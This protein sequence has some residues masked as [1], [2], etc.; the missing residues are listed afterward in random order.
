MLTTGP[1]DGLE[2]GGPCE[3]LEMGG[4][5]DGLDP[6]AADASGA[7]GVSAAGLSAAGGL[8]GRTEGDG[9]T[10]RLPPAGRGGLGLF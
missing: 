7:D 6:G 5:C 3:G 4:P 2:M 9:A 8:E 10:E 1:W